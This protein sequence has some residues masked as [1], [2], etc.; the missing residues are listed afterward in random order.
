[1]KSRGSHR[2]INLGFAAVSLGREARILAKLLRG[3]GAEPE[4][5]P[6]D[7][8]DDIARNSPL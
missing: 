5:V 2:E 6:T 8:R 3:R 1:L 4:R 7:I